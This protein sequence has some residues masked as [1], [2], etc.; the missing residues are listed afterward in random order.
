MVF[1]CIVLIRAVNWSWW[2]RPLLCVPI[3]M[4]CM[5]GQLS[6]DRIIEL[7]RNCASILPMDRLHKIL[8][9][10]KIDLCEKEFEFHIGQHVF[11]ILTV[12]NVILLPGHR[13]A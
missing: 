3:Y 11:P 5:S 2:N 8:L 4:Q 1:W 9:Y 12:S 7:P 10:S 6:R 13:L